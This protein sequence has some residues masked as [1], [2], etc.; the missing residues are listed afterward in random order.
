MSF[1]FD[2]SSFSLNQAGLELSLSDFAFDPAQAT[3]VQQH[4]QQQQQQHQQQQQQQQQQHHQQQ[5]QQQ[6]QQQHQQKQLQQQE[7]R[8]LHNLLLHDDPSQN[9]SA[10]SQTQ[11]QQL[12]N[13]E[14]PSTSSSYD[15]APSMTADMMASIS[16]S[17]STTPLF[18]THPD[19]LT[20]SNGANLSATTL[21]Q[22]LQQQHRQQQ[23]FLQQQQQRQQQQLLQQQHQQLQQFPQAQTQVS[24]EGT[25]QQLL[26][27][28]GSEYYSTD[29]TQYMSPLGIQPMTTSEVTVDVS[30]PFEEEDEVQFTPLISP[31]MTP[32]HPYSNIAAPMSTS[33]EIFSPLTSPAL[34]PHRTSQID[35]LSF[36][37]PGF[38][39]LPIQFQQAHQVQQQQ[40]QQLQ[41]LQS[42]AQVEPQQQQQQQ[43]QHQQLQLQHDQQKKLTNQLQQQLQRQQQLQQQ[44]QG[45]GTKHALA[46]TKNPAQNSQRPP[47]KRRNTVERDGVNGQTSTAHSRSAS[48]AS[49]GGG[50]VRTVVPKSS[51]AMR[52]MPGHPISLTGLRKQSAS[53]PGRSRSSSTLAPL[54]PMVVQFPTSNGRPTPSPIMTGTSQPQALQ[55]TPLAHSQ[56]SPSPLLVTN[57]NHLSMRPPSPAPFV[58]PASSM[59]PLKDSPMTLP[60]Q[61]SQGHVQGPRQ[62]RISQPVQVQQQHQQQLQVLQPQSQPQQRQTSTAAPQ[63]VQISQAPFSGAPVTRSDT[64]DVIMAS[65]T[66]QGSATSSPGNGTPKSALAPVTPASLMNLSGSETTPT[67]SPKFGANSKSKALVA[68]KSNANQ[69]GTK[70]AGKEIAAVGTRSGANPSSSSTS[71]SSSTPSNSGASKRAASRRHVSGAGATA[72]PLAPRTPGTTAILAPMPP[73]SAG[74]S[75]LISPALKPTLMPQPP[76]HRGSISGQAILVSPRAQ[77]LLVSPSLKPWLPGVSTSEA[78]ARLASKSNYQN[79]L[80]GD[81][82]YAPSKVFL[83]KKSFDHICE[84]KSDL[85]Q[86]HLRLAR[87]QAQQDFFQQHLQQWMST[88]PRDLWPAPDWERAWTMTEEALDA[89][90]AKELQATRVAAEMAEQSALAVERARVGNPP[91]SSGGTKEGKN[92]TAGCSSSGGAGGG[93]GSSQQ[94]QSSSGSSMTSTPSTAAAAAAHAAAS[95]DSYR[96][97]KGDHDDPRDEDDGDESED[98]NEM[99]PKRQP[100]ASMAVAGQHREEE[101]VVQSLSIQDAVGPSATRHRQETTMSVDDEHPHGGGGGGGA[102]ATAAR[103]AGGCR[104]RSRSAKS[105][106]QDEDEAE[107]EEDEAQDDEERDGG[108]DEEDDEEYAD[109]EEGEDDR[110]D[111][112]DQEMADVSDRPA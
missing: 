66:Q 18:Q 32:S 35:Y 72:G 1:N 56:P 87:M 39:S 44:R 91:L 107:E 67:S 80:D 109:H 31:A 81:H 50:P 19:K 33:N 79:I 95:E 94:G 3:Q 5:Q 11:R 34:Q 108:E 77:P 53:A 47:M 16:A 97:P 42:Q 101:S 61:Q 23:L 15:F 14:N 75:T 103:K 2:N 57:M 6:L 73:P 84:L 48:G 105:G 70:A 41:Q 63:S 55:T 71:S 88:L 9:L 30:D 96:H 86:H 82:T 69:N 24:K 93:A 7:Q 12:M 64:T 59:I 65:D 38:S 20:K 78:M 43:L 102:A 37:G 62:L 13:N 26:T 58:L 52:P 45:Q 40:I 51:P 54:S 83:L 22:Q 36:S 98:D 28:A 89:A 112:Q 68:A 21:Q 76:L 111:M 4:L 100:D 17:A 29:Y 60:M 49:G 27:P 10:E 106:P 99:A 25:R 92:T 74:F 46:D 110:N 85:A 90:T 104:A 8:Q